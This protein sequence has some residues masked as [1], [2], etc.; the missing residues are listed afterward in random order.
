[1]ALTLGVHVQVHDQGIMLYLSDEETK[2]RRSYS[3]PCPAEL[4]ACL[5]RYLAVYRPMLLKGGKSDRL[6]ITHMRTPL[7]E[8]G[9]YREI[10]KVTLR[11]LGIAVNPHAFRDSLATAMILENPANVPH[12]AALLGHSSVNATNCHYNQAPAQAAYGR[13]HAILDSLLDPDD[14]EETQ[15]CVP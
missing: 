7:T 8:D 15:P 9:F 5:H 13:Y 12:A 1:M 6:W 11:R 10:R 3:V 14:E 2:N 4:E